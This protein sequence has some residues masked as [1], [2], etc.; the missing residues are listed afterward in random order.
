LSA[1]LEKAV[2]EVEGVETIGLENEEPL[3]ASPLSLNELDLVLATEAG[4]GDRCTPRPKVV[5][6][7]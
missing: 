7:P 4:V 3:H 1:G 6:E 2:G 5:S